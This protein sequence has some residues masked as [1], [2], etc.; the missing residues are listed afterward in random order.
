MNRFCAFV[1]Y[2]LVSEALREC[3]SVILSPNVAQNCEFL[4]TKK[5]RLCLSGGTLR[6]K[7]NFAP[8]TQK[9]GE[10][11]ESPSML[12]NRKVTEGRPIQGVPQLMS[13]PKL[14]ATQKQGLG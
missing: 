1:Q 2:S 14:L 3:R 4:T 11:V 8:P 6:G 13:H 7:N 5:R 10:P 9:H 12:T